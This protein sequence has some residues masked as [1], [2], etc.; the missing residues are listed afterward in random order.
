MIAKFWLAYSLV[1]AILRTMLLKRLVGDAVIRT[2]LDYQLTKDNCHRFVRVFIIL[3]LYPNYPKDT[4][5]IPFDAEEEIETRDLNQRTGNSGI[6][7][8]KRHGEE[9]EY[10]RENYTYRASSQLGE[11]LEWR[12]LNHGRYLEF[13]RTLRHLIQRSETVTEPNPYYIP[14]YTPAKISKTY[15]LNEF[16]VNQDQT[17][18]F[19]EINLPAARGLYQC[20]HLDINPYLSLVRFEKRSFYAIT[21]SKFKGRY[22]SMGLAN[23]KV[24][25]PYGVTW[26]RSTHTRIDLKPQTLIREPNSVWRKGNGD[27]LEMPKSAWRAMIA[28]FEDLFGKTTESSFAYSL[29]TWD[30]FVLMSKQQI[31]QHV[32]PW[33][34]LT[35]SACLSYMVVALKLPFQKRS[36][37][38]PKGKPSKAFSMQS[39]ELVH[40]SWNNKK[41][42][43]NGRVHWRGRGNNLE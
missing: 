15:Y 18:Y 38:G 17:S 20:R 42:R 13:R 27:R 29:P 34:L 9:K 30:L 25:W 4:T 5:G 22:R 10:A 31:V 43:H 26:S 37:R 16:D 3:I 7:I 6:N 2:Q 32:L 12:L 41:E 8:G 11:G 39:P 1:P 19:M 40:R 36:L 21:Q 28:D 23:G 24:S 33:V 14:E 35:G